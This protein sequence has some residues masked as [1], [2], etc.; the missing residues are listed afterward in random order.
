MVTQ[1]AI[2]DGIIIKFTVNGQNVEG[3]YCRLFE[4]EETTP[5]QTG[6]G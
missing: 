6:V 2:V 1:A 3:T 4:A 5:L